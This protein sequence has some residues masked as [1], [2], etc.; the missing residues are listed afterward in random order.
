MLELIIA[1]IVGLA[2]GGIGGYIARKKSSESLIGSAEAE[3]QRILE[4]A[5]R[6]IEAMK[7]EALIEA[8]D[9]ALQIRNE[10]E[11]EAKEIRS[12]AYNTEKRLV[13]KEDALDRKS[14]N[15]EKK[16][17]ALLEKENKLEEARTELS[18]LID[19]QQLEVERVAGLSAEEAKNQLF[20]QVESDVDHSLAVMI[21]DKEA[22]AKASAEKTAR[23]IIAGA[24]QRCAAD[25]VAESTVSVVPL[26]N[27]EMK[28]RI[29]GREGRNIRTLET[30]TGVDLINPPAVSFCTDD[31]SSA[32]SRRK[33]SCS[34][35][36]NRSA[37][38][39]P[40]WRLKSSSSTAASI[41]PAS[42]KWCT[43]PRRKWT[44]PFAKPANR[45]CLKQVS[46]SCI[47]S[48]SSCLAA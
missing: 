26:P 10:A 14:T 40:V 36:S 29:I 43:R 41:Q 18:E 32:A 30:I 4:A 35:A 17:N 23:N 1:V 20:N 8:K 13:Q 19:K 31:C 22:E 15:L 16:E 9:T 7:K 25:H 46:T 12:E 11:V 39:L 42:K 2:I 33:P 21:K 48:W 5:N 34:P 27:D 37:A 47:R 44:R 38:R 6:D 24:I 45:P 3:A 28:G